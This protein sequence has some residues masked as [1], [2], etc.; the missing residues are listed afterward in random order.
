MKAYVI[1]DERHSLLAEQEKILNKKFDEIEI[2]KISNQDLTLDEME[3]IAEDLHIKASEATTEGN[4]VF[5]SIYY[6]GETKNAIVFVSSIPY[7]LKRF[8]EKSIF[9]DFLSNIPNREILY[10][11]YIFHF[12]NEEWQLIW[13]KRKSLE[14]LEK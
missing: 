10:R 1:I 4:N 13:K 5:K 7:L 14:R 11:V 3:K 12:E 2:V 8:T 6:K 9:I